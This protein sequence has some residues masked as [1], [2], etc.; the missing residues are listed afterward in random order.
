[1]AMVHCRE[2]GAK[3]SETA[4]SCPKCGA[5]Q[6]GGGS[7]AT[8]KVNW[9]I[10]LLLSIFVGYFGVDRFYMGQIGLGIVKFITAGGFLIWWVID[11]ILIATKKVKGVEFE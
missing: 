3:I 4:G 2:C 9:G 10:A 11:I 5:R 8:K 7:G 6:S 1:M